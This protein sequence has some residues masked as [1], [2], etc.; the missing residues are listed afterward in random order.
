MRAKIQKAIG[1]LGWTVVILFFLV[2]G[3]AMVRCEPKDPPLP[4]PTVA[5]HRYGCDVDEQIVQLHHYKNDSGKPIEVGVEDY[6]EH[7]LHLWTKQIE[8]GV[9]EKTWGLFEGVYRDKKQA[10]EV[11]SNWMARVKGVL[12]AEKKKASKKEAKK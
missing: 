11:C 9:E 12:A 4:P 1:V 3:E 8:N 6:T 5:V 10:L 2:F 7:R